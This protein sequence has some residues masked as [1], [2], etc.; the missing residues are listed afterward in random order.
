MITN[1]RLVPFTSLFLTNSENFES[2]CKQSL[3]WTESDSFNPEGKV[4][5]IDCDSKKISVISRMGRKCVQRGE[6][7][8]FWTMLKFVLKIK[9]SI[10]IDFCGTKV[11]RS[12]ILFSRSGRTVAQKGLFSAFCTS[13]GYK[14]GQRN[15]LILSAPYLF[16][17]P[18][19][20]RFG[21]RTTTYRDETTATRKLSEITDCNIE[22]AILDLGQIPE[23]PDGKILW[24]PKRTTT[25]GMWSDFI[26]LTYFAFENNCLIDVH[27]NSEKML[28]KFSS[29][30]FIK[31][32]KMDL[33]KYLK[34]V[35]GEKL[36]DLVFSGETINYKHVVFSFG[37]TNEYRT[38]FLK[39][40]KMGERERIATVSKAAKGLI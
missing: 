22:G 5:V 18:G 32:R 15:S 28:K 3:K 16:N 1:R 14:A 23:N 13:A 12:L 8:S 9:P 20:E 10:S 27:F 17:N 35:T 34:T 31:G 7:F 37:I 29:V 4:F 19:D 39:F 2:I 21:Y 36:N 38:L 24:V 33:D 30:F 6:G 11:S 25:K 26:K 40:K